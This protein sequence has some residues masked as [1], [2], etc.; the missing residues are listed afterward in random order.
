MNVYMVAAIFADGALCTECMTAESPEIATAQASIRFVR[1]TKTE[2]E[3]SG[4][5][6]TVIPIEF[7]RSALQ[8][9]ETGRPSGEVLSL[10]RPPPVVA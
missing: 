8:M 7:L 4:V 6:A 1:A 5:I 9:I 2:A 10:V 3:L